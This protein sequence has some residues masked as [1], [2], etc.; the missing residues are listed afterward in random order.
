MRRRGRVR[1]GRR[2]PGSHHGGGISRNLGRD[3]G[4][5]RRGLGGLG[6][7]DGMSSGSSSIR[8]ASGSELVKV[9]TGRGKARGVRRVKREKRPT[10]VGTE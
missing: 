2:G 1:P 3:G 10:G 4:R 9:E 8:A 5:V 7:Q 6:F